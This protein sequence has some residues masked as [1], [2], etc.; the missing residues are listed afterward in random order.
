MVNQMSTNI[1]YNFH[2][3]AFYF[4]SVPSVVLPTIL[5]F[6]GLILM[7]IFYGTRAKVVIAENETPDL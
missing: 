6:A 4:S 3:K 7:V 5:A 2:L 1:S